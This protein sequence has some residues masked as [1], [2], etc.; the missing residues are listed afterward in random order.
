[1]AAG[2]AALQREGGYWVPD[3]L[4]KLPMEQIDADKLTKQDVNVRL[5]WLGLF[6]RRKQ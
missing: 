5:K 4:T 6:H 2:G 1:G 3:K